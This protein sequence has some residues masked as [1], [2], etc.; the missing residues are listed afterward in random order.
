MKVKENKIREQI[1][2]LSESEGYNTFK[3]DVITMVMT[4]FICGE[5]KDRLKAVLNKI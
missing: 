3:S 1:Y 2:H 4:P 5:P